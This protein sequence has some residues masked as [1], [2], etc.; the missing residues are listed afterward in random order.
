M[1]SEVEKAEAL[2]NIDVHLR[3]L[4]NQVSASFDSGYQLG[5]AEGQR[6]ERERI[7]ALVKDWFDTE[8]DD[9]MSKT[10]ERLI[11]AGIE[12]ARREAIKEALSDGT[13]QMGPEK[14]VKQTLVA[15]KERIVKGE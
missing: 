13:G 6:L 11:Y 15:I 9:F 14:E 7:L 2:E 10:I 12:Y 1:T 4:V 3:A 5:K 8:D